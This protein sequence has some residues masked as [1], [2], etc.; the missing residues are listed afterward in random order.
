MST[1]SRATFIVAAASADLGPSVLG[2]FLAQWSE[3]TPGQRRWDPV[4]SGF[5]HGV[6]GPYFIILGFPTPD[7]AGTPRTTPGG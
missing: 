5:K 4:Q 1:Q 7:A 3:V 6:P 2:L